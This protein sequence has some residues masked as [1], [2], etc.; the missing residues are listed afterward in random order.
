[1]NVTVHWP[2][3]HGYACWLQPAAKR[4]FSQIT[5]GKIVTFLLAHV[6]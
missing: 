1:M 4:P 6:A 2:T 5:L 3:P